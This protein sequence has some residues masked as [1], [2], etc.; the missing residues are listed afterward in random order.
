MIAKT[1]LKFLEY[2]WER[3]NI[4]L[5]NSADAI[6][7]LSSGLHNPPGN[8]RIIEWKDPDRFFSGISLLKSDKANLLV[9]TGGYNPYN[10]NMPLEG[11]IYV[12]KAISL[13]INKKYLTSTGPAFNTAQEALQIKKILKK[14]FNNLPKVI[15]IT[16]AFH[17]KRAK[18]IFENQNI[19]VIP[20][21]VDFKSQDIE[22]NFDL[23]NPNNWFISSQNLNNSSF[24]I[25]ELIGRI[26]YRA[27]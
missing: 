15:L 6:V 21:P 10:Q 12:K 25:R 11:D 8:S 24:A 19:I 27:W 1:L 26:F 7:V 13:G 9:F 4:N 20:Y 5:V 3:T 2:P 18:R 17:M 16:S 22:K 23:R 14:D